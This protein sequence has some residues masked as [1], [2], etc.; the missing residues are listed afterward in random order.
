MKL[1]HYSKDLH[2]VL[3]TKRAIGLSEL[4]QAKLKDKTLKKYPGRHYF[5]HISFFFDPIPVDIIGDLYG[6]DHPVWFNG[7]SL[8][9]HEISIN[10]PPFHI[11][12]EVVESVNQIHALDI[13]AVEHNWV[14]EDPIL[15]NKWFEHIGREKIKWGEWG[16]TLPKLILQIKKNKG[17]TRQSFINAVERDDFNENKRKYAAS[18]PHLMV[19][20][21]EGYLPV[22]KVTKVVIGKKR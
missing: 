1:F 21:P 11:P 10:D 14:D 12:F 9:E 18:V 19:Y 20:P 4:E 5:D 22:T 8:Y 3:K 6:P 15:L 17:I 7:N 2:E 16:D 13:F